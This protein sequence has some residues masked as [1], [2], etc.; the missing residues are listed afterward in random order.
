MGISYNGVPS[1]GSPSAGGISSA[2]FAA[3]AID[4]AA[5]AANALGAS[6]LATDAVTEIVA[7][8]WN[9]LAT[10]FVTAGSMGVASRRRHVGPRDFDN[11]AATDYWINF[12]SDANQVAAAGATTPYGL[13]GWGFVTTSLVATA[14]TA[15]DFNSSSDHTPSHILTDASADAFV[16]PRMFGGYDQFQRVSTVLGYVPTKLCYEV[17][18]AF[19][20][21][22]ANETASFFG[23]VAP[24][25][26]DA[27]AAGGGPCIRSGGT[28]STF[29]LTS[30]NGSDAGANIDTAWHRWRV[31]CDATNAEWF[32][33]IATPGT[34]A[35]HG[36][37]A[38][39]ADIWPLAWKMIVTT[40]NRIGI[41]WLHIWYE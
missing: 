16:T 38:I 32:T 34:M 26:T 9:G 37:I 12:T 24:A 20:V 39:E 14:G 13:S 4:A 21:A 25:T 6:E 40:T 3:G 2:S 11:A 28:A 41:S 27:A 19:T 29:F 35:S 17:Y 36:T 22:S 8:N 7:G 23:F 31:D 5:I 15:G 30:D 18:A 1:T 10:S 33:D